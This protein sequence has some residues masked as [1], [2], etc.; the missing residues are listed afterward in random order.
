MKRLLAIFLVGAIISCDILPS[1][2]EFYPRRKYPSSKK[3]TS[4]RETPRMEKNV[5]RDFFLKAALAGAGIFVS[6]MYLQKSGK[7]LQA[8]AQKA[9][10]YAF[11]NYWIPDGY[12]SAYLGYQTRVNR[13]YERRLADA[14]RLEKQSDNNLDYGKLLMIIGAQISMVSLLGLTLNI[15]SNGDASLAKEIRF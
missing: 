3:E 8:R 9:Y 2:A 7:K 13:T 6:G 14:E 4:S 10:V 15:Q 12:D 11:D 5:G 1:A